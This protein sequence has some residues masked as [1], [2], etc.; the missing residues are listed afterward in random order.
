MKLHLLLLLFA[1]VPMTLCAQR[2]QRTPVDYVNTRVGT[3]HSEVPS[4]TVYGRGTEVLGQTLPAVLEPNGQTLWTPQT[5]A[6]ERKCIAPYYH[7]D[8]LFM[9]IRASHWIVGGC[10]QDYGS[11]TI[12]M[13]M[14]TPSA[15]TR[16]SHQDEITTPYYYKVTLP[17]EHLTTELT[18][19]SHSAQL[20]YVFSA[21]GTACLRIVV[22]SDRQEGS[23]VY[24]E[25][26]RTV[27]CENPVRRLYQGRGQRAGFSG[28]LYVE[29]P[30][31]LN[32]QP[33][34]V[35][36]DATQPSQELC[37]TFSVHAGDTVLLRAATSFTSSEAA[38]RNL[39][40]EQYRLT[41]DHHV[42][43]LR[44]T[45]NRRLS[46][47]QA[48]SPDTLALR[49]FYTA[50]YH[51]A[52][53]P[54]VMSDSDRA[55]YYTDFSM[56]DTYRALHPLLTLLH[57]TLN[58]RMMQSLVRFAE[59]GGWLPT[60]PCWDSYTSGMIGD[61]CTAALCDAWVKG[62]R[63]FDIDR[64]YHFMR[65][66]AFQSPR[67]AADYKDGKGRRALQSYLR[68]GYIP[69]EDDV[70]DAY[71]PAE[72]TSRT[73]EYAYDDFCLAQVARLLGHKKDADVL[74]QR[75]HNWQ[76]VFDPRTG[77]VNGRHAD[78]RFA[79]PVSPFELQPFITEGAPCR[80]TFYVPHE[81]E[82]L[83][84]A[85]GGKQ[86][87]LEKLDTLFNG[88]TVPPLREGAGGGFYW[89]GNEPCHQIPYLYA[90]A[91]RLDRT[92]AVV[93][94]LMAEEYRDTPGGLSGNDDAGQMSAWYVFSALGFYPVCP[95]TPYYVLGIPA[96]PRV[97]LQLESHRDFTILRDTP[98]GAPCT[99]VYL[100]GQRLDAPLISHDDIMQGGTLRFA[101]E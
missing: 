7:E 35:L 36:S 56:W 63:S 53:L 31:L 80:Y 21:S 91:G 2:T 98:D 77:Y 79:D 82:A 74:T 92:Q 69:L 81:V 14:D 42:R 48:E 97:T 38:R 84:S 50:L 85:M 75:S 47:V 51:T 76:H 59:R 46:V 70:A 9:G 94:R 90:L 86:R 101:A 54:R 52:F 22:N 43:Q 30:E 16:F 6:T 5:R 13:S 29:L 99:A 96:F 20:R 15:A 71:H 18:A 32:L 64:A 60:F 28:W 34:P 58:G 27:R 49:K 83:M 4:S 10:M 8:S 73:L 25:V 26:T 39:W 19:W 93:R 41:F 11:A 78:G 87:F 12:S 89:H 3:A 57:P 68:Y 44:D 55:N 61:H 37:L 24:D 95:G 17:D 40:S 1:W 100:N 45:W 33:Q 65:Q 66:N 62:I 88:V 23:V 72:Q 67:R